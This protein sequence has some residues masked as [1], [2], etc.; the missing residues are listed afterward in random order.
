[1]SLLELRDISKSYGEGATVV[2]ALE[3]IDLSVDEGHLVAVMGPSGSGKSTLLTIAGSL[4][5]PTSGE[6]R[7]SGASL[8]TMSRNDK[9]RLRRRT[10][11]YV[12]QDFNLLPGLT[13]AE[14]VSLPLELDGIPARKAHTAGMAALEQ[15]G[16]A[17]RADHYPG[18]ALRRRAPA[19]RDRP[20]RRR[21]AP[22]PLGGRTLGCARLDERRGRDADDPRRLQAWGRRGRG[23]PR[24]PPRVV[25]R[26]GRVP[27]GRACRRPRRAGCAR[28]ARCARARRVKRL[29]RE[30]HSKGASMSTVILIPPASVRPADGGA[31]ARRAVVRWAWRLFRRE[32]RQQFL[33]LALITVAVAA[34]IVG[35]AVATNTPPPKNS[36]FGTAQDSVTF[37]TY[38]AHTASVIASL[39]HRFGRVELIENETQ[40]IPG[41][42]NTYQLRC[43][44]SARAL[45]RSDALARLGAL[46]VGSRRS[47][48]DERRRPRRSTS[49]SETP[50]E[51]AASSA[52]WSAS[53][54]TP[55]A[56]ST[57][58]PWS[59][60][61]R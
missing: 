41:S 42:I 33:I 45:Q 55:R 34:T 40:S 17:D 25:G 15:L 49:R 10:I 43:A 27:P 48:R 26:P 11:G 3:D 50:G 28:L 13:A 36:G 16:L 47:R 57:S 29:E 20:S 38:D 2:H 23:H 21:R 4:E 51:S 53:S 24:R 54:R 31:P 39:E 14:N 61:G 37:T 18:P 32:W 9:A 30:T 7:I 56:S 19:G 6:V 58:S 60:P 5:E 22:S 52:G 1:M 8:S 35:S 44:G 59:R 46:P 12:F